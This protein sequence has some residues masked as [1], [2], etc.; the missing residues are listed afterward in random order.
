V[1][2]RVHRGRGGI[3][4]RRPRRVQETQ[5]VP[6][7]VLI[8]GTSSDSSACFLQAENLFTVLVCDQMQCRLHLVWSEGALPRWWWSAADTRTACSRIVASL[9]LWGDGLGPLDIYM[10][11]SSDL[12]LDSVLLP[13]C[14]GFQCLFRQMEIESIEWQIT[15]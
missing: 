10:C 2:P 15:Q 4:R 1:P 11:F 9:W 8:E 5:P 13:T 3:R 12:T 7:V 6:L 14:V